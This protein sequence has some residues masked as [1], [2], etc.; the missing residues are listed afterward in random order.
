MEDFT[1]AI[2]CFVD[3]FLKVSTHWENPKRKMSDSEVITTALIAAR[4]FS[5]N[6]VHARLYMKSGHGCNL[7][8]KS[9][10]NRHL[11]RLSTKVV[12]IF[13]ALGQTLKEL[14]TES[15][16]IIDSFPVSVCRNIRIKRSKL[17]KDKAYRGYNHSKREYFYGFKVVLITTAAGIP[18]EYFI[19]A[20][21]V[22]DNTAFQAM[23]IGLAPGS[24]LYAD[25]AYTNYELEDYYKELEQ[26]W[27][28][29]ERK[30][31]SKRP[32]TPARKR[33]KEFMRKQIETSFSGIT[34]LFPRKIHAVTPEGFLLKV[35][36]FVF[37]YTLQRTMN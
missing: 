9:N 5:G 17:L 31:N 11:H 1:I 35:F 3:D 25:S 28:L 14:N 12:A 34:N 26:I 6:Y 13:L 32:D 29:A 7:P 10:F 15:E 36:L 20:G 33:I 18:V 30:S 22:H 37:A 4:Y 27:L 19:V 23:N 24:D 8:D 2:Y 21:S 16:Y